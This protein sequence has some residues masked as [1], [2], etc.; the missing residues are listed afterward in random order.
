MSLRIIKL[1]KDVFST[2]NEVIRF[3]QSTD[4]F[5]LR[6]NLVNGRFKFTRNK[7]TPNGLDVGDHLL[8]SY[9]RVEADL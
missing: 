5:C 7:I 8:F 2:R 1:G 3:F 4:N 9:N 6:N